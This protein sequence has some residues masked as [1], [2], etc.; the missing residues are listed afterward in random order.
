MGDMNARSAV[1]N[2]TERN[3]KG[4]IFEEILLEEDIA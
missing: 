3:E 1:W 4:R 2:D